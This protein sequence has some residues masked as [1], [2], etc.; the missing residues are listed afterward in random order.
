MLLCQLHDPLANLRSLRATRVQTSRVPLRA[1]AELR[2][3]P[4]SRKGS[5]AERAIIMLHAGWRAP[6]PPSGDLGHV[7]MHPGPG[8]TRHVK[9]ESTFCAGSLYWHVPGPGRTSP[10]QE[11]VS[12]C[13]AAPA[14][15]FC[16]QEPVGQ[17]CCLN[18]RAHL[19]PG[20]PRSGEPDERVGHLSRRA[21]GARTAPRWRAR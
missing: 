18:R 8:G 7:S 17:A 3:R 16:S 19:V 21:P 20:R 5:A 11:P 15:G 6:L 10:C 9:P 14:C 2:H 4:G 1:Q 13:G 12:A